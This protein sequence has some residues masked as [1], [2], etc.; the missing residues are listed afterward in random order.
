MQQSDSRTFRSSTI[1]R[2]ANCKRYVVESPKTWITIKTG[3]RTSNPAIS[4][5]DPPYSCTVFLQLLAFDWTCYG[6]SYS[7]FLKKKNNNNNNNNYNNIKFDIKHQILAHLGVLLRVHQQTHLR[8]FRDTSQG[9]LLLRLAVCEW[10]Q[11]SNT[12]WADNSLRKSVHSDM[13]CHSGGWDLQYTNIQ[14]VHLKPH[15]N[16]N[17]VFDIPVYLETWS[18]GMTHA[19]RT[20]ETSGMFCETQICFTFNEI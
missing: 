7:V 16:T 2:Y 5:T 8:K 11:T 13:R 18:R 10:N 20:M 14:M 4:L 1:W 15:S 17:A 6:Y 19:V 3:V 9:C 12:R